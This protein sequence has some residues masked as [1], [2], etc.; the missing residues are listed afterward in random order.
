M[1]SYDALGTLFAGMFAV[2]VVVLII[3][4]V[5]GI[6][7]IVGTWKV[8]SKAN[9]PGWAALIP[10]YNT[11]EICKA[12]GVSPWWIL[13]T[14]LSPILNFIP[15]IG[16]IA[17]AVILI[18]FMI[19]LNVSLARSFG[20]S[21]AFAVGLILLAPIFYLIL[22]FGDANYVGEKPMNDIIFNRNNNA[23]N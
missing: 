10:F 19:L 13:I 8:L 3:T 7:Q 14:V 12:A 21:D 4:I 6:L 9:R 2:M 5:I 18:Y 20:K 22:A 17:E 11:Y 15:I 1:D 23:Q 16:Q